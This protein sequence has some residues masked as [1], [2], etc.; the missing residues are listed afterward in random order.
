MVF[1]FS[2]V[3]YEDFYKEYCMPSKSDNDN[4][5][6][7]K[8]MLYKRN[9]SPDDNT[10]KIIDWADFEK[11]FGEHSLDFKLSEKWQ[12]LE[13]YENFVISFNE[14]LRKES[15]KIDYSETKKIED[16]MNSAMDNFYNIR[17]GD[18]EAIHSIHQRYNNERQYHFVSFNYTNCLDRCVE[19]LRKSWNNRKTHTIKPVLHIHGDL[20]NAMILGVDDPS[21]IKN[22]EF[23]KDPD[24]LKE[25]VKPIQNAENRTTFDNQLN[26]IIKNSDLICIYGMSIGITDKKWWNLIAEWLYASGNHALIILSYEKDY[27][28]R[29]AFKQQQIASKILNK[30]IAYSNLNESA[31]SSIVKRIFI[32]ANNNIFAMKI[33]RKEPTD[34]GDELENSIRLLNEANIRNQN[35]IQQIDFGLFNS[36]SL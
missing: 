7:F 32:G 31:M 5:R 25:I 20:D 8:E 28:K 34:I 24:V 35:L 9:T 23:A 10:K 1:L 2:N 30:F 36:T 21:Q 17:T 33:R 14:Y 22:P 18:R 29:F 19:I 12:Y 6:K 4:I 16:I 13:R 27:D 3:P 15:A 11:A 26:N